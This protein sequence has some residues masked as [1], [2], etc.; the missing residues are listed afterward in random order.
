MAQRVVEIGAA[1]ES[2][3]MLLEIGFA[4]TLVV[5]MIAVWREILSGNFRKSIIRRRPLLLPSLVF[6]ITILLAALCVPYPMSTYHGANQ[7]QGV[8]PYSGTYRVYEPIIYDAAVQIR[9]T[10]SL[11]PN[12]RL[13]VVANFWQDDTIVGSLFMNLVADDIDTDGGT[14]RTMSLSPGFYHVTMNCTYFLDNVQQENDLVIFSIYQPVSSINIPELTD[15]ST[16]RFFLEI[17]CFF[18]VIAGIC[19]VSESGR[20]R[21]KG[22]AQDDVNPIWSIDQVRMLLRCELV[23]P[24]V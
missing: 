5:M 24:A 4:T 10:T 14:V 15:W 22:G 8:T 3:I 23:F 7:L 9:I 12:E 18:L 17:G 19:V 11:N 6:T 2:F 21:Q 13:E 20:T 16:F 1:L